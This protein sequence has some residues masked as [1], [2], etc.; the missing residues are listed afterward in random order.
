MPNKYKVEKHRGT[1]ILSHPIYNDCPE[2]FDTEIRSITG[3]VQ[4]LDISVVQNSINSETSFTFRLYDGF[5]FYSVCIYIF[6][7]FKE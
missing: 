4:S 2:T 7:F 6:R 1:K 3:C 5:F